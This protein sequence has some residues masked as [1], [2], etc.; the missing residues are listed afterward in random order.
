MHRVRWPGISLPSSSISR[1][2]NI[3]LACNQDYC[4]HM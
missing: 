3:E 1:F 4:K 2:S